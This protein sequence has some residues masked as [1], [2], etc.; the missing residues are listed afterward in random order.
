MWVQFRECK[1][2][3]ARGR[4]RTDSTH[5][6]AAIRTLNRLERAG[7]TLRHALN[8][9]AI[10]APDWLRALSQP[11]WIDRYSRRMDDY[12]L[13]EGQEARRALAVTIGQDGVT[14]LN[15]VSA[16]NAP[17]VCSR[18]LRLKH[19]GGCGFSSMS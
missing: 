18:S 13:P 7:E 14:L 5:V 17:A 6:L 8:S 12:H 15:A 16:A 1:L 2:L 3:S 9:L 11:E 4:Q 19:C 10:A